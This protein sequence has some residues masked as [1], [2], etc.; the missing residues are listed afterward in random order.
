M[1]GW[2]ERGGRERK[3]GREN[4]STEAFCRGSSLGKGVIDRL[5][6]ALLQGRFG[7]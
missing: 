7:C 3:N 1:K 5:L 2:R 4:V 6:M